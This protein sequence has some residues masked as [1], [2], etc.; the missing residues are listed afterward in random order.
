LD[1]AVK[2]SQAGGTVFL[3]AEIKGERGCFSENAQCLRIPKADLPRFFE[4]FYRADKARSRELGGTGLGLSIVKH[5]TQ[6]HGGPVE[7]ES[8]PGRG[9]TVRVFL[10]TNMP[11]DG[12]PRSA[13]SN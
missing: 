4:R 8:E 2:Y 11:R 9:T 12:E 10:P 6:L 1:N 13:P 7:A 5:I 3:R